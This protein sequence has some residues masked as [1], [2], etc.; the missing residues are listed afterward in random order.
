MLRPLKAH[1]RH[2]GFTL[3]ELLIVI[4]VIAML[5]TLLLPVLEMANAQGRKAR[6][7][8]NL[9]QAFLATKTYSVSFDSWYP[10]PA[11]AD[12]QPDGTPAKDDAGTAE[13]VDVNDEATGCYY[14]GDR[15]DAGE[16]FYWYASHNW[17]GKISTYLGAR[18]GDVPA[19][20]RTDPQYQGGHFERKD[21]KVYD[22][23]KC[24]VVY[25]PPPYTSYKAQYYGFNAYAAMY[26][27]Q[28]LHSPKGDIAAAHPETMIDTT[29][30]L[31]IGENWD[32]HWAVKPK[33][34]RLD[35]DFPKITVD[36]KE[37]YAGEVITRH[38]GVAN[39]VHFDG[40]GS[41][42]DMQQTHERKC[43]LWL[44]DKEQAVP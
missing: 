23:L 26:V 29:N 25:G 12:T 41:S 13:A 22:V 21:E 30:T 7:G 10:S 27:P 14:F 24:T 40:H 9:R 34:P 31:A 11:Y 19:A 42:L 3:M 8:S 35:T 38:R 6:C 5:A 39:W 1:A 20:L 37:I 28:R 2:Q 4:A 36:G 33:Y 32:S 18:P 44:P 15:K 43:F 17:R 16:G